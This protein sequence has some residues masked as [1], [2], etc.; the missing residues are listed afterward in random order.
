MLGW[1][2]TTDQNNPL[3]MHSGTRGRTQDQPHN[4][5]AGEGPAWGFKSVPDLN[6]YADPGNGNAGIQEPAAD[7]PFDKPG[8]AICHVASQ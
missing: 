3:I 5:H 7:Y 4:A 2:R 6:D 8:F 1:G